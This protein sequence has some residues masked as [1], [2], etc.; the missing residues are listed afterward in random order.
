[1]M[2]YEIRT[3][4]K[5]VVEAFKEYKHFMKRSSF[6]V[7]IAYNADFE[8]ANIQGLQLVAGRPETW[9]MFIPLSTSKKE[10]EITDFIHTTINQVEE[11]KEKLFTQEWGNFAYQ[12]KKQLEIFFNTALFFLRTI[13][14][15]LAEEEEFR[16]L[17]RLDRE[18]I[19]RLLQ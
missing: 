10:Y 16:E 15:L 7:D 2:G 17:E 18:N 19:T 13:D 12:S 6:I 5:L 11:L 1:M 14:G 8:H 4:R 9:N 3:T